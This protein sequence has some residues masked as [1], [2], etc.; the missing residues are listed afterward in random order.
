MALSEPTVADVRIIFATSLG[1]SAV[2]AFITDAVLFADGCPAVAGYSA[3]RQAAIVKYLAAHLMFVGGH[4][5]SGS[6]SSGTK[7]QESVGDASVSYAAPGANT[8]G[9]GLEAS[10]FGQQALKLETSGCLARLGKP[11]PMLVRV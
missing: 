1:D 8:F 4:A 6:A 5:T 11:R 3:E 2:Q 9:L 7:T 10:R